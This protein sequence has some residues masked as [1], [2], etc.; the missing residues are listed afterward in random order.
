[1]VLWWHIMKFR[2]RIAWLLVLVYLGGSFAFFYYMFEINEHYNHFA[3]DHVQKYHS[4][5]ESH[6]KSQSNGQVVYQLWSHIIDIPL[7]IW[8]L[9]FLL[10]YLQLFL[11]LLA[12]TKAEPR[13]SLAY[14]WPGLLFKK[15]QELCKKQRKQH[16]PSSGLSKANGYSIIDTWQWINY[17]Q[18]A[19]H[20]FKGLLLLSYIKQVDFNTCLIVNCFLC[21]FWLVFLTY[22]DGKFSVRVISKHSRPLVF[23]KTVL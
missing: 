19:L 10:P 20:S 5:A 12:C 23:Y 9:I 18:H 11:M 16:I 15:F 3:L 7:P 14:I 21:I 17:L 1:M 6:H 2:Q 4:E 13:L 8:L 22:W